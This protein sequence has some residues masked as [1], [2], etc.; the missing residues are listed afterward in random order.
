MKRQRNPQQQVARRAVH[1]ITVTFICSSPVEPSAVFL[2]NKTMAYTDIILD[3]DG[4]IWNTTQIVADGWNKAIVEYLSQNPRLT[5]QIGQVTAEQLQQEFGKP[6]NIIAM[7]LWPAAAEQD[8]SRLLE[9]CVIYEHEALNKCS[10]DLTYPTVVQ[11]IKKLS[12]QKKCRFYIV[13]NCQKGYV[14]IVLEKTGIAG[15][16]L[17]F[18]T[19]GNTGLPKGKNIRLLADRNHLHNP[20]YVGDTMGDQEA[21]H[22]AGVDFVWAS[23]GFGKCDKYAAKITEFAEIQAVIE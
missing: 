16:I 9:L 20:L 10:R 13:S 11:T 4:T 7:D 3:I 12:A 15:C 18:E 1:F 22:E 14:E 6:M 2:Y 21:S 19:F 8:R 23:Y 5:D 17:D